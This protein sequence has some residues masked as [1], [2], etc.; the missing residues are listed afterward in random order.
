MSFSKLYAAPDSFKKTVNEDAAKCGALKEAFDLIQGLKYKWNAIKNSSFV[1]L[2]NIDFKK[3][4][5][6]KQQYQ[7]SLQEAVKKSE[8]LK[9]QTHLQD[10]LENA[11][12]FSA[13]NVEVNLKNVGTVK[14]V[15]TGTT[16]SYYVG[17]QKGMGLNL[18]VK[19]PE[20]EYTNFNVQKQAV[21]YNRDSM[22]NENNSIKIEANDVVRHPPKQLKKER[23]KYAKI[24]NTNLLQFRHCKKKK[25][26]LKH[27]GAISNKTAIGYGLKSEVKDNFAYLS[28]RMRSNDFDKA[29][30]NIPG[31]PTFHTNDQ[32]WQYTFLPTYPTIIYIKVPREVWEI[33]KETEYK[34]VESFCQAKCREAILK[35][36][37]K[38]DESTKLLKQIFRWD[39]GNC[40]L[41]NINDFRPGRVIQIVLND[42]TDLPQF[43]TLKGENYT[44]TWANKNKYIKVEGIDDL[45]ALRV[46]KNK[47]LLREEDS[48]D[49]SEGSGSLQNSDDEYVPEVF[50]PEVVKEEVHDLVIHRQIVKEEPHVVFQF[51]IVKEEPHVVFQFPIVKEE[52]HVVFQFPI[53]KEEPHVVFQFPIVKEEPRVVVQFPIVK[54]EALDDR[55]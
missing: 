49:E 17:G 21:N 28:Y 47:A 41:N 24:V 42:Y 36:L 7:T 40:K 22:K 38:D 14:L 1:V 10:V 32:Q 55:R 52:P 53:V 16:L 3:S 20:D 15:S 50:A 6:K 26:T 31:K 12:T 11:E 27:I 34:G 4:E 33:F 39:G 23:K 45:S 48:G 29:L 46:P 25:T 13:Q 43:T 18:Y 35:D 51:P 5:N 9:N 2:T 37:E 19:V 54:E 8:E 44:Y 30:I